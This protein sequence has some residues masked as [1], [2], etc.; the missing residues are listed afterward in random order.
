MNLQEKDIVDKRMNKIEINLDKYEL[1][2]VIKYLYTGLFM[3]DENKK[4]EQN[5][6]ETLL[7]KLLSIAYNYKIMDGIEYEKETNSYFI[8]KD[9]EEDILEDYEEFIEESFWDELSN[10]LSQRDLINKIGLEKYKKIA[11]VERI[12]DLEKILN[13]YDNEFEKYGIDRIIIKK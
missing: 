3:I 6:I 13:E 4:D 10:R 5:K 8:D 9:K 2:L 12:R 1:N 7:D 11:T